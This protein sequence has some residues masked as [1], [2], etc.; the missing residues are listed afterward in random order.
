MGVLRQAGLLL[1]VLSA[2]AAPA[3][4]PQ[5][6][7]AGEPVTI[8][9]FASGPDGVVFDLRPEDVTIKLNG[10]ARPV[11]SLRYISLPPPDPTAPVAPVADVDPPF[12]TNT[13]EAGGRWVTIVID[14][15][16]IKT[17]AERNAMNA[18]IRF[19]RSL[20]PRDHVAVMRMPRGGLEVLF[21]TDHQRVVDVLRK[22]VGNAPREETE[23]DRSCRSRLM[24]NGM[25]NLL[26]D[27]APLNGPKIIAV[28]SS[29]MLNPRRDAAL[30]APPGPCE[31]R[32]EDFQNVRVA[33]AQSRAYVFVVQ[34]DN[35]I[36]ESARSTFVDPTRSRFADA[37][38]D[39]HGLQSLAGVSAGQFFQI[40][41]PDDE[42]FAAIAKRTAGYYIATFDPDPTERNAAT[43]RLDV[44][45]TRANV[46]VLARPEVIIPRAG[47]ASGASSARDLLRD[48]TGTVYRALPLRAVAY[49]SA[50]E[51]GK[52][53]VLAALEPIE[54]NVKLVSAV[55]GLIDVNREKLVVQW[56]ADS[57]ELATEPVVTA[58]EASPGP[59]RLRVA[60]VDSNGRQG[61]VEYEFVATL[62]G[63]KPLTLSDM[64]LG[65]S[66][67]GGLVPRLV[68]GG[69]QA[70]VTYFEVY[71][72]VPSPDALTVRL[73]IAQS[74]D[75]RALSSAVPRIVTAE[76]ERRMITGT[77]PIATLPPG[78]YVVRAIVSLD[79][80]P[81]GRVLRTLRKSTVR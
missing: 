58:G 61:T 17:G 15:E 80:R 34:P 8:D 50:S 51:G 33:A 18:A 3:A 32:T 59:Y 76:P 35:L 40:V 72:A 1:L 30:N 2:T 81:I 38:D 42:R 6:K 67:E 9:F 44:Q 73:E 27:V 54:R 79:G 20:G 31:I 39:R 56:T 62:T 25:K 12:G 19:V 53:K 57:R 24:L 29:G 66:T 37:D 26:E 43:H 16:S 70:A 36:V 64:A 47:K 78:D 71:G 4:Q 46:D 69:D 52:V 14:H 41:G 11:R 22:F 75:D 55:F 77:L 63:A 74:A 65:T 7:S 28:I 10:R 5:Q 23:Q 45:V 21:T 13:P 60:A 68:F 49:A 48:P